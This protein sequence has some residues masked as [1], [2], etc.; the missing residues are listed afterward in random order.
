[1][2]RSGN[3]VY[4]IERVSY[5]CIIDA[6]PARSNNTKILGPATNTFKIKWVSGYDLS[7]LNFLEIGYDLFPSPKPTN[8]SPVFYY[9]VGYFDLV[10]FGAVV[11]NSPC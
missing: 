2:S 5:S 4:D 7:K 9:I 10:F 11:L 1:M 3:T 8:A 6:C